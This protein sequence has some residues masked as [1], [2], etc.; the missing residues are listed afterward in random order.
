MARL[1]SR[2]REAMSHLQNAEMMPDLVQTISCNHEVS[3]YAAM[4]RDKSSFKI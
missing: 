1:N 2:I 3:A 4:M